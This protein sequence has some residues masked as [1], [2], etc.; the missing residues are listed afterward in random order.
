MFNVFSDCAFI[1]ANIE[2][3]SD[4]LSAIKFAF[5]QWIS[6][7]ILVR[8]GISI[9]SYN[10]TQTSAQIIAPENY[11]GSLF[12]G[13]AVTAAVKLEGSGNGAFLFTNDK[14]A[15]YYYKNYKEPIFNI[16]NN[17]FIGWSD[18]DLT[19]YCFTGI[20]FLRLIKLLSSKNKGRNSVRNKLLNNIKYTF[21]ATDSLYPRFLILAI[22][23]SSIIT[24]KVREKAIRLLE[25]NDPDDFIP[26]ENLIDK[27]LSDSNE[28]DILKFLADSDSSIP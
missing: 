10:E 11:I 2:N 20:S 8:G 1:A 21:T 25:I 3:A 27:W 17:I 22:L 9:G 13:S 24:S 12:S 28:L 14:C 6:D 15:E 4:L 7:G 16:E 18:E 19:L 5:K 23:S 26:F